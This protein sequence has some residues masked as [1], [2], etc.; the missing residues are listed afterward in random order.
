[1]AYGKKL[2]T[3]PNGICQNVSIKYR[4]V[5]SSIAKTGDRNMEKTYIL[6][7]KRAAQADRGIIKLT[8]IA[9]CI[10]MFDEREWCTDMTNGFKYIIEDATHE[11][12]QAVF[13]EDT[14]DTA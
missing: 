7:E 10:D 2:L 12:T 3:K 4:Q 6:N 11:I 14:H 8:A 9:R 13:W 5:S 1:M